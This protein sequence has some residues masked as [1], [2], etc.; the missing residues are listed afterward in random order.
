MSTWMHCASTS[1]FLWLDIVALCISCSSW[2]T[3]TAAPKA[4]HVD[5]KIDLWT[6]LQTF[7]STQRY[8]F[9]M[10]QLVT[11]VVVVGFRK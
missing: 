5:R 1:T 7:N 10:S 8:Q 6:T 9:P 3:G 2:L 11:A 4:D